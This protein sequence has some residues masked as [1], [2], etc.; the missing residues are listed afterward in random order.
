MAR[1]HYTESQVVGI[2]REL[3]S[4][5]TMQDV[6]RRHGVHAN[7]LR[8]WRAKYAG[9]T[10]SDLVRLRQLQ[11]ENTKLQRIVARQ[12]LELEAT[13]ELIAKNGRGPHSVKKP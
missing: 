11:D 8:A 10:T 5:A 13:R 3:D 9:M 6:S 1:R 7:T 12:A 2:L 4:G